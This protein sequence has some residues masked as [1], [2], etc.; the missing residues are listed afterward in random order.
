MKYPDPKACIFFLACLLSLMG[1]TP[2]RITV[3]LEPAPAVQD[4]Q[5]LK[6]GNLRCF[7][8]KNYMAD[9][10]HPEWTVHRV[11]RVNV[12]VL[13]NAAG[14]AHMPQDSARAYIKELLRRANTDLDTNF[15]NWQSPL[16]TVVL[17]KSYSYQLTPQPVLKDDGIYFHYDDKLW[18]FVSK[19]KNQNN[20]SREVI[21]KYS[22]GSDSI[23]NIF[24]QVHPPD[25]VASP[26]YKS[27]AQG[28]ALGTSLKIAGL[29]ESGEPPRNFRGLLNHEVGHILGVQH[30]WMEDGCPDTKN[31]PNNCW[32]WSRNPPCKDNASNN[33]MDYNGYQNALT[34][35]QLAKIHSNFAKE[36]HLIR[37]CLVPTWCVRNP[38]KDR[39]IQDSIVWEGAQDLEG[40]LTIAS[41]AYLEMRCRVSMPAGSHILVEPGGELFINGARLHNSCEKNWEGIFIQEEGSRKG[42]VAFSGDYLLEHVSPSKDKAKKLNATTG[43]EQR[44]R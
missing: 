23:L 26:Y 39:I 38:E 2:K 10:E 29:L 41:G 6:R 15:R 42:V 1:C 28:I 34:P 44:S 36:T 14:N 5:Q 20:Y 8:W 13:D 30:A 24:V 33:M 40:N 27:G 18:Y 25:S 21:D 43:A 4:I 35:C 11:I 37:K 3:A 7:D 19:G 9:P 16:G 22:I 17:P 12:H 31:H 32:T